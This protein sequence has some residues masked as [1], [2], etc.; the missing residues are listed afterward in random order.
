[1]RRRLELQP[2]KTSVMRVLD[3]SESREP[4]TLPI[5]APKIIATTFMTVPIPMKPSD[6]VA[7]Y[8]F[9]ASLR[10]CADYLMHCARIQLSR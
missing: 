6:I 7:V 3:F 5:N 9:K 1:M 2:P 4:L 8:R 10:R